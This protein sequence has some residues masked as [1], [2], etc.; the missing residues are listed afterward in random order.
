MKKLLFL[1]LL[2][3]GSAF[4]QNLTGEKKAAKD[5]AV[6]FLNWYK[7][8]YKG[9][10]KYKLY[11]SVK[12]NS[13]GPPY[14]INWKNAEKHFAWIRANAPLFAEAFIKNEKLFFEYCN[15]A[16]KKYP[17]DEMP[18]GFDYERVMGTQE[19]VAY[20][21]N[22]WLKK[23]INWKVKMVNITQA[24]VSVWEKDAE[25][26]WMSDE[27]LMVK[28]SGKWKVALPPGMFGVPPFEKET[29]Q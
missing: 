6:A 19:E 20:S 11:S 13:D 15:K 24:E 28:E 23:G 22:E 9:F 5:A 26:G 18:V 10:E 29:N 17:D 2:C 1:L 7:T 16:F 21:I 12:P 4:A 27:M 8:G 14:T 25:G 3:T